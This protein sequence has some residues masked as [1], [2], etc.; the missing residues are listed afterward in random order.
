MK[1]LLDEISHILSTSVELSSTFLKQKDNRAVKLH[2]AFVFAY[3][4]LL[5]MVIKK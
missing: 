3:S 5:N 4:L 2:A 1:L